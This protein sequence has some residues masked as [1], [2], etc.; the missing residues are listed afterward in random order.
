MEEPYTEGVAPHGGPEPCVGDPRGRSEALDRG[1]HRPAIEPRNGVN[2]GA[3]VVMTGGRQHRWRRYARVASG[4]REVGEPVHVRN[5]H[6]REPGDPTIALPPGTVRAARGRL[7]PHARDARLWEV[8]LPHSTGEAVEQGAVWLRRWWREGG[9]ARGTRPAQHAPDTEPGQVCQVRWTV[10]VGSGLMRTG[11]GPERGA[12]CGSSARWDPCGGPPERAVPT[13]TVGDPR[14]RSEALDRGTHRPAIEPRNG[15]N[16]GADV[17]MT[18]GRQ[19]RWRR[20]ARVASGPREVGEPVHVRNLHAREPGDPTIA[21]PPGTVRAARGRLRPH[22]RDARLWEVGLPHSTGEAVEQGAVWLR[23]WWREGGSARG[24]RPA[25]HAPDTEP[26]QVCQVRW[27][28]CVGSG[29]MRTGVG[30][31]RGAQCGSSARWDPCGGPPE[32]AVPTATVD[33]P[34]GRGEALT[35]VRAGRA[36]EPRNEAIGVPTLYKR[37]KATSLT[38]LSRAVGGPRVVRDPWHVRNLHAREPGDPTLA[39]AADHGLGRSGNTRWYA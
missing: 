7:R 24:T 25:Q 26:G 6:A 11:V 32:R 2:R 1:T 34:R 23:R 13:A 3:D 18:G 9:S 28:V 16:R 15:V 38:A 5:L 36:I 37:R 17:V 4:P 31:E 39:Q 27:T 35:G 8:G 33:V 22:A 20:Y 14:G 19:H 12:Q 21:L 30:P 29:L 10:C